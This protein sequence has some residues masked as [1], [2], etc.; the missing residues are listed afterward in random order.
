MM[1]S[2]TSQSGHVTISRSLVRRR[3]HRNLVVVVL[4]RDS[5][6]TF[7]YSTFF[8]P[9]FTHTRLVRAKLYLHTHQSLSQTRSSRY[10]RVNL[11]SQIHAARSS[12]RLHYLT[13][14]S[15][16]FTRRRTTVVSSFSS[17]RFCGPLDGGRRGNC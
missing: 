7:N 5:L 1:G 16:L 11:I 9:S 14:R 3:E 6:H 13:A 10:T 15:A 2:V 12:T 17:I 8:F 4:A